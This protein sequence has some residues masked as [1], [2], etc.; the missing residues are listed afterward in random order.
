[1]LGHSS[2]LSARALEQG[3]QQLELPDLIAEV[4]SGTLAAARRG[5]RVVEGARLESE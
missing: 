5:G 1:M 2:A 3:R 4:G